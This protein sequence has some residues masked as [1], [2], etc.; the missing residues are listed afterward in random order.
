MAMLFAD[1]RLVALAME[2][3]RCVLIAIF[4]VYSLRKGIASELLA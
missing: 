1:A 4:A 3:R 2:L